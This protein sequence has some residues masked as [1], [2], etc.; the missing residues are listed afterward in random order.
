MFFF[1]HL[2][3]YVVDTSVTDAGIHVVVPI[4]D[5]PVAPRRLLPR[6]LE[7]IAHDVFALFRIGDKLKS[8]IEVPCIIVLEEPFKVDALFQSSSIID[9]LLVDPTFFSGY[10]A[11]IKNISYFCHVMR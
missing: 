7:S 9:E 4:D 2:V 5:I 8:E 1:H 6:I 3:P 11:K 10:S